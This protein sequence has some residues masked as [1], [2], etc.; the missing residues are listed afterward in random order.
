MKLALGRQCINEASSCHAL[1]S[2]S[3]HDAQCLD[4]GS[5]SREWLETL[6][7]SL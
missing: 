4:V 5:L 2:V 7:I 1:E 3:L 6:E